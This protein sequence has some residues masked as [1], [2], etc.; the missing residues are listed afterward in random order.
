MSTQLNLFYLKLHTSQVGTL[1]LIAH[2]KAL[3]CVVFDAQWPRLSRKYHPHANFNTDPNSLL[4]NAAQQID[5]YLLGTRSQFSI[6]LE[7][8]GTEFQRSVWNSLRR[9]P[10]GET[11]SYR[12]QAEMLGHP[13][14]VRAIANANRLNPLCL[15]V[16]C[17]RVIA[18][19]GALSGYSG[20]AEVKAALLQIEQSFK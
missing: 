20:G 13:N 6:P 12:Q 4:H 3:L 7:L 11:I 9:I 17:H 19:S 10:Y 15:V 2:P 16:P 18:H 1:H 14:S 8:R 5:E